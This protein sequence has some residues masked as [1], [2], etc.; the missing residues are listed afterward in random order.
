MKAS[1]RHCKDKQYI[2]H[3]SCPATSKKALSEQV[4]VREPLGPALE[5][6]PGGI[7]QWRAQLLSRTVLRP[8]QIWALRRTPAPPSPPRDTSTVDG[9]GL[10]QVHRRGHGRLSCR[11]RFSAASANGKYWVWDRASKNH[12]NCRW[13]S[14]PP[15][16]LL[17]AKCSPVLLGHG[18]WEWTL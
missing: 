6:I 16:R 8:Q 14:C 2:P 18:W 11:A 4:R 1:P 15:A 9:C 13:K 3:S 12:K 7:L 17:P 10:T 5:G